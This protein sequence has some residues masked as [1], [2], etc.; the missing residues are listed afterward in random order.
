MRANVEITDLLNEAQAAAIR[1]MHGAPATPEELAKLAARVKGI[2]LTQV[3][4]GR[5]AS[6][7]VVDPDGMVDLRVAAVLG[8]TL[9]GEPSIKVVY[10]FSRTSKPLIGVDAVA[11]KGEA[12]S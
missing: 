4:L 9:I 5:W 8:N 7:G 2:V 10:D 3:A 12:A 11:P 6:V 1:A